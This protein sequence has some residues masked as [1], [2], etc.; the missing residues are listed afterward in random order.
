DDAK[1]KRKKR[2]S[3]HRTRAPPERLAF[4][5]KEF[6]ECHRLSRAQYYEL[7]KRGLTPDEMRLGPQLVFI[8]TESAREWRQRMTATTKSNPNPENAAARPGAKARVKMTKAAFLSR[9]RPT[10]DHRVEPKRRFKY[11]KPEQQRRSYSPSR[12]TAASQWPGF[13]THPESGQRRA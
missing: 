1:K 4:T 3:S 6:C 9:Q 7:K 8:T 2:G 13:V 5:I 10:S 12:P 11:D